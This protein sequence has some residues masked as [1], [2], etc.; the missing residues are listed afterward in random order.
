VDRAEPEWGLLVIEFRV[1]A[2]RDPELGRRYAAVHQQTLA[3]ME[4]A[5]TGLYQRAGE[6]P[7]LLPADLARLLV[8]VGAGARL[9]QAADPGSSPAALL[10]VQLARLIAGRPASSVSVPGGKGNP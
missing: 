1:L 7:P 2:A 8:A 10:A 9:E 4:R 3:G 6:P 5:V